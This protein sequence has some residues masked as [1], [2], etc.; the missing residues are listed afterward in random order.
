MLYMVSRAEQCFGVSRDSRCVIADFK[1]KDAEMCSINR[2]KTGD[3]I[4]NGFGGQA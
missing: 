1:S 2:T 4:N 3:S